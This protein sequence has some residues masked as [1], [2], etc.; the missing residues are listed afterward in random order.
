[1]AIQNERDVITLESGADLSSYQHR[2]VAIDGTLATANN[3]SAGVVENKPVAGEAARVAVAGTIKG[4]AGAAISAGAR[5]KVQSGGWL[6]TATSGSGTV[7]KN[8]NAAVTSGAT[9]SFVG[10]FRTAQTNYDNQ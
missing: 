8:L 3:N 9:F 4:I 6:I 2:V 10:D 5:L 7:G 1:M